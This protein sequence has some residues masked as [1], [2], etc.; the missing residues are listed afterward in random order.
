MKTISLLVQ[1]VQLWKH[2]NGLFKYL[3]LEVLQALEGATCNQD[4]YISTITPIN[5]VQSHM[6][7]KIDEMTPWE[8]AELK[9]LH[10]QMM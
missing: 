8:K 3:G 5:I 10:E 1:C 7:K 9:H 4:L 6:A 2:E